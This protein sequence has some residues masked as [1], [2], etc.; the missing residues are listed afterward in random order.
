MKK[1]ASLYV[2]INKLKWFIYENITSAY[3]AFLWVLNVPYGFGD[4]DKSH[5]LIVYVGEFLPP[6]IPRMAKWTSRFEK[7]T[8]ILLCHKRGFYE[9]FTTPEI[10][11]TILFRNKWHLKRIIRSLPQPYIVHGFAPKS[12][13]P[14]IAMRV[15]KKYHSSTPFIIDYQDVFVLYYGTDSD[16]RWLKEELPYEK[17]CFQLA[18]GIVAHSLEP[19]EGMRLWGIKEKKKRL[20]F[21]LYTD[22]DFFISNPKSYPEGEIHFVYA[23]GVM[24]SHRDKVHYGGVQFHWLIDY[25]SKQKI[26]FHIYPSPSVMKADY[27]EYEGI[28]K[29][30]EYFHFHQSV[31]QSELFKELSKYHYG[32]MPFFKAN[33]GQSELKHKYATTLKM[34]NYMEAGIPIL[35]SADVE[36]QSWI[37][38]RYGMG[39][40]I[41]DKEDFADIRRLINVVPY[42]EQVRKVR[43]GREKLSL[44]E[45]TPRLIRFY[46][47]LAASGQ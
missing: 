6:R 27:E 41:P 34:F 18:N 37:V 46:A 7:I 23:G 29:Q 24:G 44:R 30:N 19:R 38:N 13:F 11:V 4:L 36:Y 15:L 14:C 21:P 2:F 25:L 8:S 43:E 16:R 32:L 28:A 12:K 26:H 5:K 42:E 31:S 10:N 17:E 35:V 20:F 40:V 1:L 33:S 45:H 22:N 9:K 39:F 3:D 47:S